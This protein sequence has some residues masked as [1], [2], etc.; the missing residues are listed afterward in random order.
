[1]A[2]NVP[3]I[4][5]IHYFSQMQETTPKERMLKKIRKALIEKRE[6]PY[7]RLEENEPVYPVNNELP[8]F[9]FAE[10]F[11]KI[12]G[13][14]IFCEDIPHFAQNMQELIAHKS[15]KHLFC[16]EESIAALLQKAKIGYEG[17]EQH[18][19]EQAEAGITGCEALAARTGSILISN[20][21]KA[22][23][24]LSVYPHAHIVIAYTSQL[25]PDIKEAIQFVRDKYEGKLPSMLSNTT[26]PSRTADIEKTLVLG[27]HGPKE[28][29]IRF[30]LRGAHAPAKP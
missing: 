10:E 4:A 11:G 30:S 8:E 20:Q 2:L 3:H 16:W 26:G 29:R 9:I 18:F 14:F 25:K 24:R 7:P 17:S 23:R 6:N 13:Q 27:A 1:M 12:G 28:I 22:G 19:I 21:D 15:W 5:C